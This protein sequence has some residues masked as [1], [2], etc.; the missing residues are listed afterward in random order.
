MPD[1]T[2]INATVSCLTA[3]AT[4]LGDVSSG[5][6][7]PGIEKPVPLVVGLVCFVIAGLFTISFALLFISTGRFTW[8]FSRLA[9]KIRKIRKRD[10]PMS[11]EHLRELSN[12]LQRNT[13]TQHGWR[14]FSETLLHR[15]RG[16]LN[17]RPAQ[18]FFPE[19]ELVE[20][21]I[22]LGFFDAVP[23]LLTGLGLFATF[24]S[25]YLGLGE[26]TFP[27]KGKIVGIEDFVEALRGKFLSSVLGLLTAVVFTFSRSLRVP[28]A[29]LIYRTFCQ[30]FDELFTRITPEELLSS[31]DQQAEQQSATL[32]HLATD[33]SER[34]RAGMDENL[35][36]P[37]ERM[38]DLLQRNLEDRTQNFE[39]M[40]ANLAETFRSNFVQSTNFEF[41]N[42]TI[43]L[44]K[45]LAMVTRMEERSSESQRAFGELIEN[46]NRSTSQL[47]TRLDSAAASL[48]T[49]QSQAREALEVTVRQVL[50][51]NARQAEESARSVQGAIESL[52]VRM[53]EVISHLE[54]ATG[55]LRQGGVDAQQ[56]LSAAAE[57]LAQ[58]M[59]ASAVGAAHEL[60][61]SAR[62]VIERNAEQASAFQQR[63]EALMEREGGYAELLGQQR[64]ALRGAMREFGQLLQESKGTLDGLQGASVGAREAAVVLQQA[65]DRVREIQGNARS[66]IEA[67]A[68]QARGMQLL[69][70]SNQSLVVEF[71]R[72]FHTVEEGLSKAVGALTRELVHFQGDATEQLGRQLKIFDG[73]LG[74]A[75]GKLGRAVSDLGERLEDAS[76]IIA[77]AVQSVTRRHE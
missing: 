29:H 67:G 2:Q 28:K 4:S 31:L 77:N 70:S 23:A 52:Q 61:G 57:E 17:T 14:E 1:A 21:N 54:Q 37:L 43:A 45:T 72:V 59:S 47:S 20:R 18:D 36:P 15:S 46:L 75:T 30:A 74:E 53:T 65:A 27:E 56:R 26:L 3:I 10:E 42:V 32:K 12:L 66:V 68:E 41:D 40:A 64:E 7:F 76:E 25:L 60:A 50:A 69:V 6:Q 5:C 48:G 33:L 9:R 8:R 39:E 49:T 11:D 34:F 35:R 73:H 44:E 24:V 51:S 16:I 55:G 13:S 22:P 62:S 58:R 63:L 38:I 19:H 71:E